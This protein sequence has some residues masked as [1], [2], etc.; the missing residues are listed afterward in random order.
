MDDELFF[1]FRNS[2]RPGAEE[3]E[4]LFRQAYEKQ[5]DGKLD[6]AAR[7]YKKSIA[8]LPTSEA[9]TFLGWVYSFQGKLPAAIEECK[10]AIETDPSF[11]N[12]YNDIGAYLIEMGR[13]QEAIPW[14]TRALQAARYQPRH[15]PH[16]NLARA[17]MM[18]GQLDEAMRELK[19]S[20][21]IEPR[22]PSAH[23]ELKRLL[24]R[25]N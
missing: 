23:R 10:R 13:P 12:P 7:L 18:L 24:T 20:L 3:A 11:G 17:Y 2:A 19:A 8:L 5:M 1:A 22:N 25:M 15:F 14:L 9:Y 21:T 16:V 6:E 4:R